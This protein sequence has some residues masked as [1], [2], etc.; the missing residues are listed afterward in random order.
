MKRDC[1]LNEL[2]L[3]GQY[4]GIDDFATTGARELSKVLD[5]LQRMGWELF[6]K[7][8]DIYNAQIAP[9]IPLYEVLFN[10]GN[11]RNDELRRMK[12]AIAKLQNEPY[13]DEN[14][15]QD[16]NCTYWMLNHT[17]GRT[18]LSG[19][20]IAEGHARDG[21]LISFQ[22]SYFN[23]SPIAVQKEEEDA[24]D[25]INVWHSSH[26]LDVLFQMGEMP[27]SLY[28]SHKY[29]TRLDF[30]RLKKN[31]GFEL[32]NPANFS[33]F[34][35]AFQK[36]ESLS[37]TALQTDDGLDYKEFSKN[38]NTR[39][40]FSPE[41]WDKRIMKFRVSSE[42]RCFGNV[43]NDKFYLLR[44]DLDHKLSDLG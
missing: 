33:L 13:W 6:Y 36:V 41:E 15:K 30:C 29:T 22:P 2:S 4:A 26:L 9:G 11:R 8:S 38:R 24:K 31:Y 27:L 14:P 12:S 35:A 43:E 23:F 16:L 39:R 17:A 21:F 5:L 18:E 40:F 32:I 10:K 20:G 25:V 19:S 3:D 42:I 34:D 37:W 7:K 44:I 1:I 28:F